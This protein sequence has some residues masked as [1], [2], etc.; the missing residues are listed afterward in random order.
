MMANPYRGEVELMIE[1]KGHVMRL[2]LGAL[3][4]LEA[5]MKSDNL[6]NM[7]ERFENAKFSARDLLALLAAGLRGGGSNFTVSDLAKAAIDGGAVGAAQAAGRL[8]KV[9]FSVPE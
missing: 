1:G 6:M 7:V 9:T 4:E 5:D 3:A 2:T 8:L